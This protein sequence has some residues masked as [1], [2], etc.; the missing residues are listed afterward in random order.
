MKHVDEYYAIG[1]Q[2]RADG[3]PCQDHALSGYDVDENVY[4]SIADGCSGGGATDMGARIVNYATVQ[5]LKNMI[6]WQRHHDVLADMVTDVASQRLLTIDRVHRELHMQYNDLLATN[7]YALS[8]KNYTYVHVVGDGIVAVV[9]V[10]GSIDVWRYLWADN[11]PYYPAYD[12]G[13]QEQFIVAHGGNGLQTRLTQERWFID[14]YG[15]VIP[16]DIKKHTIIQGMRGSTID[17]SKRVKNALV[18]SITIFSD[19]AEL[20]DGLSWSD[21][22]SQS[23]AYKNVKGAFVKRRM[24]RL[25][26]DASREHRG[27]LDD[28]AC[29]TIHIS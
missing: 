11:T 6:L 16:V 13:K 9:A 21:V 14:P 15:A 5:A 19:G 27:P 2:H 8:V 12:L 25:I 26:K 28:I 20:V 17:L 10:D 23:V 22:V 7:I 29:A 1:V 18:K 24:M 3:K 4:I